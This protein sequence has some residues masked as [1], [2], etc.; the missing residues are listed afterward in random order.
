MRNETVARINGHDVIVM[1]SI[2]LIGAKDKDAVVIS[3]SHGGAISAGF[4]LRHPPFLVAFNDAGGGRNGAGFASLSLLDERKV[5]AVV[6]AH[7]SAAI[8]DSLDTWENGIVSRCNDTARERGIKE[9]T[10]IRKNV[11]NILSQFTRQ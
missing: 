4:A 10:S 6:I 9:K 5:A 3:S 11:E 1:D 7:D 8:G 2:S